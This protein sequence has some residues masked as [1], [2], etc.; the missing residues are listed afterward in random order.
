ML[1]A[2]SA[3]VST[4]KSAATRI[5]TAAV[6]KTLSVVEANEVIKTLR[7]KQGTPLSPERSTAMLL[8]YFRLIDFVFMHT[9]AR[10]EVTVPFRGGGNT[11]DGML[12]LY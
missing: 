2:V 4:L 11:F 9:T 8:L 5:A 12:S 7:P 6:K 1:H 3:Q 10:Y